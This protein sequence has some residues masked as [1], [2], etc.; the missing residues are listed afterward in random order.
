MSKFESKKACGREKVSHFIATPLLSCSLY[1]PGISADRALVWQTPSPL[2][3]SR[4]RHGNTDLSTPLHQERMGDQ[5][6]LSACTSFS[7]NRRVRVRNKAD[8]T[9]FVR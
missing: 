5:P 9:R 6:Q 4:R 1:L 7:E 8:Y 3:V 2:D